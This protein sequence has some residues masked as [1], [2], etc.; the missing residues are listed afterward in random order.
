LILLG[1]IGH[2]DLLESL[3]PS[4]VLPQSVLREIG[5]GA[6]S[7]TITNVTVSRAKARRIPDMA[8]TAS[9]ANWDLGRGKRK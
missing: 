9:V 6:E 8:L 1:K 7:D 4:L 3:A 2:L 5:A